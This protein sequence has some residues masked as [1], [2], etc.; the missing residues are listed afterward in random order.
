M[1]GL[2]KSLRLV[3]WGG[4]LCMVY[5]AAVN[6]PAFLAFVR[7]LGATEVQIGLLTGLPM[8]MLLGQFAGAVIANRLQRRKPAFIISVIAGRLLFLPVALLPFIAGGGKHVVTIIVILVAISGALANVAGPSWFSWMADI[9]PKT[10]LN[11]Y[12]GAR[13][14]ALQLTWLFATIA[15]A[16][17]IGV[18]GLDERMTFLVLAIVG[19][20]AGVTDILLFIWVQEP[21]NAVVKGQSLFSL[22]QEPFREPVFRSFVAFQ[23]IWSFA[24]MFGAS[25]MQLYAME[26]MQLG[27]WKTTLAWCFTISNALMAPYW[28]KIADKHGHRSIIAICVSM[29]P[30]IVILFLLIT[31]AYSF[32]L[33]SIG[34]LV[35][36]IWNAGV[37]VASSGYMMKVSP[38][39]NRTIFVASSSGLSGIAGGLG[40]VAAG[41][42]LRHTA[43]FHLLFLGREW[44]NYHVLFLMNLVM[45]L[46][47]IMMAYKI[48]EPE[49]ADHDIVLNEIRGAWPMRFL[50]FPVGFY[51]SKV[52]PVLADSADV[53]F[54]SPDGEKRS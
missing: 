15:V 50:L 24:V 38:K 42:V 25:F 33:L 48:K 26:N 22:L 44:I 19:V 53:P 31:P 5:T 18:A 6:S 12:W 7:S 47:C 39:K 36:S 28:G 52:L 29:K 11:R 40:A 3:V 54:S 4:S 21:P 10:L 35:D 2:R 23:C 8:V 34:N 27:P 32:V 37:F 16:V 17:F 20:A 30:M 41:L 43:E 14:K 1:S 45:R 46:G 13:H 9:I 51:R 49:S